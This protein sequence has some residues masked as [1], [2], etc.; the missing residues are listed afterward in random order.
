[1][2][3]LVSLA[4]LAGPCDLLDRAAATQ[5]IG[6]PVTKVEPSA[7]EPDEDTGATRSACTYYA[8]QSLLIVIRLDFPS[9][10]AARGATSAQSITEE[11][12]GDGTVT[13]ES[14][15]GDQDYLVHTSRGAQY[16]VV[17]GATVL[18]ILVGGAGK[19]PASYDAALR[20][21]AAAATRKL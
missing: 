17:K 12:G 9:A 2:L 14:G 13:A 8:G 4:L 15:I 5:L 19:D 16:I 11:L 21:N 10:T 18:S 6:A 3:V 20:T 7:P 1:M